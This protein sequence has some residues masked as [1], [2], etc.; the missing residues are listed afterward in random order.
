MSL[1]VRQSTGK[2]SGSWVG[3]EMWHAAIMS[4][5]SVFA[6]L[7]IFPGNKHALHRTGPVPRRTKDFQVLYL[8]DSKF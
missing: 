8:G 5:V 2:A 4:A 1:S 7:A 6:T 3:N